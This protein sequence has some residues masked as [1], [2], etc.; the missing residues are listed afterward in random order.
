MLD[1][2]F[3]M[4]IWNHEADCI[5]NQLMCFGDFLPPMFKACNLS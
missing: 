3:L 2:I 1:L 5:P 4:V